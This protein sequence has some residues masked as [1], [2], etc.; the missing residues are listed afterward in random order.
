MKPSDLPAPYEFD[1]QCAFVDRVRL[2]EHTYPILTLG[3]AI[4]NGGHR[5]KAIAGQMKAMGQRPGIPDWCLP[6]PTVGCIGLYIEFKRSPKERPSPEQTIK[7]NQ[8]RQLGH[9]VEVMWDPEHAWAIV[10]AHVI[11]YYK[12]KR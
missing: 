10:R 5:H 1:I 3:Y 8:L 7:I 2:H 11:Q 6:V 12:E 9:R 4:P